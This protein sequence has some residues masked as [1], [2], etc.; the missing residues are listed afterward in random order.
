VLFKRRIKTEYPP[1]FLRILVT[2]VG[3]FCTGIWAGWFGALAA[4]TGGLAA[5][6]GGLAGWAGA[7]AGLAGAA[8]GWAEVVMPW[9]RKTSR[10]EREKTACLA[11]SVMFVLGKFSN[12]RV[13]MVAG[14]FDMC[15]MEE[16]VFIGA[17][18]EC[19]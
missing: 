8:A 3:P 14:V 7:S 19:S 4:W 13:V 17:G 1:A 5:W 16:R 2:S 15:G 18:R 9:K 12:E 6:T 11:I 10:I